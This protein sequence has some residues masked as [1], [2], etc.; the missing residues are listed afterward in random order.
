MRAFWV[1]M[2]VTGLAGLTVACQS[3][4]DAAQPDA[5]DVSAGVVADG[6]SELLVGDDTDVLEEIAED[7]TRDWFVDP[8]A[9]EILKAAG[10]LLAQTQRFSFKAESM[11]EEVFASGAKIDTTREGTVHVRRPN[12]LFVT[13]RDA[14]GER[15]LFYDGHTA[16]LLDVATNLYVK[17]DEA[18]S[19]LDGLLDYLA[20]TL[21]VPIPLGDVIVADPYAALRDP[22]LGGVYLGEA[23]IRG[24]RCHH[25]GFGNGEIEWQ[26][27]V[28][29]EGRPLIRKAVI[30]YRDEEGS[31]RWEAYLSDWNLEDEF[32]DEAFRFQAPAGSHLIRLA[33]APFAPDAAADE[34]STDSE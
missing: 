33:E 20:D 5:A 27:W 19:D 16:A 26:I 21:Q 28:Q 17:S 23:L 7:R 18:P 10:D 29:T 8:K 31:P 2:I 4:D 14:S 9:D 3:S 30:N 15:K 32:P 13:R 12:G 22:A 11:E 34:T 24:T 25:L 6:D 1:S